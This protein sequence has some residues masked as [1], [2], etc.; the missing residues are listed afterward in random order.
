MMHSSNNEIKFTASR[1]AA[2]SSLLSR[3]TMSRDSRYVQREAVPSNRF[4]IH[5]GRHASNNHH[6]SKYNRRLEKSVL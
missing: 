5:N 2:N 4:Y 1:R 6:Q 3:V